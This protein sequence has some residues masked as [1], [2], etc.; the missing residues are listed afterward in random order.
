MTHLDGEGGRRFLS[1]SLV[2]DLIEVVGNIVELNGAQ[3]LKCSEPSLSIHL[4]AQE[5][6]WLGGIACFCLFPKRFLLPFVSYNSIWSSE[7]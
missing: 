3:V 4:S 5:A 1:C 2:K 7:K 6:D